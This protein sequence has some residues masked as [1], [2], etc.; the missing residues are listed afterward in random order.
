M[1]KKIIKQYLPDPESMKEHKKLQF[2]G[3]RL[4]DPNLWHLT[5]RSVSRAFAVGLFVAWVPSPGQ[6]VIA[7]VVSFYCRA[8]LPIAVALVWLTN[9]LTWAP[10][11]YFA[12]LVGLWTLNM[13]FPGDNFEFSLDSVMAGL[14][15]IGGPFLFGCI[16]LSVV[17]S[18]AGYFGIQLFWRWHVGKQWRQRKQQR[19][20]SRL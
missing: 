1:P 5:R 18:L 3:D 4:H 9:P 20:T 13:P 14:D 19:T 11:F 2:L 7:T 16:L 15:T 8:N 10:L 12:Y 6:I 17:C